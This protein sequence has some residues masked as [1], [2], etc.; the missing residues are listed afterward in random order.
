MKASLRSSCSAGFAAAVLLAPLASAA[1]QGVEFH[2]AVRLSAGGRVISV[3]SPGYAAPAWADMNG[4]GKEDLLVGQFKD[5]K[6]KV[7]LNLGKG[8]LAA[9]KWLRASG[10]IVKVPGIW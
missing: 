4:D 5:G 3:E 8:K 9:G 7:Y 1:P 2:A 6:I 10:E